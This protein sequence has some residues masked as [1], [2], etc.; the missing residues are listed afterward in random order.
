MYGC[1]VVGAL[2]RLC[3]T[4]EIPQTLLVLAKSYTCHIHV[5][6]EEIVG[7]LRTS[8][9]TLQL[10]WSKSSLLASSIALNTNM[11]GNRAEILFG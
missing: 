10:D 3:S 9:C 4:L 2:A 1:V 6:I 5:S 8:T 11:A 7:V